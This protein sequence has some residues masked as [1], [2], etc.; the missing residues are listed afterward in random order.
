[1]SIVN[2]VNPLGMS[3]LYVVFANRGGIYDEPGRYGI[4]HLME[5]LVI[6]S[7][8][9][10]R[11]RLQENGIA[12]NAFTAPEMVVFHMTGLSSRI[13][14][15]AKEFVE[16]LLGGV[17]GITEDA[18]VNER[19]TVLQ[20][21]GDYFGDPVSCTIG[22]CFRKMYGSYHCIGRRVDIDS[23]TFEDFKKE[24]E[25][26]YLTPTAMFHVGQ[27]GINLP[28]IETTETL[29]EA[30]NPLVYAEDRKI[31]LEEQPVVDRATVCCCT[32]DAVRAEEATAAKIAV[33]MLTAG[34]NSPLYQE[35]REKR[36]LSYFQGGAEF[37]AR[38]EMHVMF[39]A[40]TEKARVS[41][42]IAVYDDVFSNLDK[43][44]TEE[45]FQICLNRAQVQVEKQRILLYEHADE[46]IRPRIGLI[47][48]DAGLE[49]LT[50][51]TVMDVAK[52]H[53]SIEH[54][55]KFTN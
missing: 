38:D 9:C 48:T 16:R 10:M 22:N 2:I 18:F 32:K 23:F 51:D 21:Y 19:S 3:G 12:I 20:E 26:H 46:I 55:G 14:M 40:P 27:T 54:I 25:A 35:I 29:P 49:T 13:T 43:H 6:K 52:R 41:E 1:M 44:M 11:D 8:D 17:D 7:T 42:L 30:F 28:G 53:L 4:S 34:L 31:E 37:A 39:F 47:D 50:F 24:Y 5:H 45:R 36:G 15:F 33:D